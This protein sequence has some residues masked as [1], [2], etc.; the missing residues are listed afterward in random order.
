V[1]RIKEYASCFLSAMLAGLMIGVGGTVYLSVNN[2]V[3]GSLLF[4]VGLFSILVFQMQLFTGKVGY[5]PDNKP[6]YLI[7][8]IVIWLGN[9]NGVNAYCCG[10]FY[11]RPDLATK[12]TTL[13]IK[14]YCK[15]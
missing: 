10:L 12:A 15:T 9:L 1:E 4:T 14:N 5:L 8:L 6:K 3:I 2:P 7:D 11:C 13:C